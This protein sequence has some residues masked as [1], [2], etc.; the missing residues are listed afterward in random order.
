MGEEGK[1]CPVHAQTCM[2]KNEERILHSHHFNKENKHLFS[3]YES[4]TSG[5]DCVVKINYNVKSS[6]HSVQ[7]LSDTYFYKFFLSLECS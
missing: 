5:Y 1:I 2:L 3:A 4:C 6:L 7:P